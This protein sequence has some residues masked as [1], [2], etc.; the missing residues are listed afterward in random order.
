[1]TNEKIITAAIKQAVKE[2][3]G[4]ELPCGL[5]VGHAS[6]DKDGRTCILVRYDGDNVVVLDAVDGE[7]IWPR[8]G[9]LHANRANHIVKVMVVEDIA[10][11]YRKAMGAMGN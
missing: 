5:I 8:K 9:L 6:Q 11:R 10:N 7:L 2:A 4:Q 1:M 3:E